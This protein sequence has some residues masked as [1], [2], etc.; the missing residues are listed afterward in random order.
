MKL[1]SRDSYD[2]EP[3]GL[4]RRLANLPPGVRWG[5]LAAALIAVIFIGWLG[6]EGVT[7]KSNLEQARTSAEQSK[8]ALL[9]GKSEDATRFAENAQFH[10]RQARAAT[11]SLPWN[12]AA[13][14]PLLGSPLKTTQQISDVVVGLA[15]NVLLPGATM[16]AGLSPDKLI[17]G[18]RLDLKLSACR[19]TAP[20]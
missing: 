11:H 5:A 10:A 9:S 7:A 12:I 16:G 13:A 6:F 1:F 19:A 14:V 18:T 17:D 4:K 15:D 3:G 20:H 2:D 8:D